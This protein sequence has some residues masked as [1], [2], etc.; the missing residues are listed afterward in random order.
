MI[1]RTHLLRGV[2]IAVLVLWAVTS[3]AEA[4]PDETTLTEPE[5]ASGELAVPQLRELVEDSWIEDDEIGYFVGG[6]GD[7]G[8]PTF[9]L[10]DTYWNVRLGEVLPDYTRRLSPIRVASW[11]DDSLA[12][13]EVGD[14]PAIGQ[15]GYAVDLALRLDIPFDANRVAIAIEELREGVQYKTAPTDSVGNWGSSAI[16][17]E[18]LAAAGLPIPPHLEGA[19]ADAISEYQL[20]SKA[21]SDPDMVVQALAPILSIA[22]YLPPNVVETGNLQ[23]LYDSAEAALDGAPTD[24]VGLA[25]RY[26][27]ISAGARLNLTV[28][29]DAGSL[30]GV[31][32]GDGL[33]RLPGT[34]DADPQSAYYALALGCKNAELPPE[35]P[36]SRAGWPVHDTISQTTGPTTAA[37]RLLIDVDDGVE[38]RINERLRETL[39]RFW[40][41]QLA[42]ADLASD[43]GAV[44]LA[45]LSEISHR[46]G[47]AAPDAVIS[48]A[49]VA[50]P[51]G[52]LARIV[53]L[54]YLPDPGVAEQE[55]AYRI[56]QET[57]E[58]ARDA[59]MLYAATLE[60]AARW[61]NNADLHS[62]AVDLAS[63]HRLSP[64]LYA[65]DSAAGDTASLTA[66]VIGVWI[67]REGE[68]PASDWM[69]A[70]LCNS[71]GACAETPDELHRTGNRSF[72]NLSVLWAC[73][74]PGCGEAFPMP[75]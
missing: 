39:D 74:K 20:L 25:T 58:F 9:S 28:R 66:S 21:N 47:R 12:G 38:E 48:P 53:A 41:P 30:C 35:R 33:V 16:A 60:V 26:R 63:E 62:R 23:N 52:G 50:G 13:R 61:L 3:C 2:S 46:V 45:R 22:S 27:L 71:N 67:H 44:L 59:P 18:T 54:S 40:L 51:V 70:G 43:S 36:Y 29:P 7:P 69:G 37:L 49:E 10:Y 73:R 65:F 24:P 56:V 17:V 1:T 4:K 15:I 19:V 8:V 55:A 64:R 75:L 32:D 42:E 5:G 6:V 68:S 31:V 57:E 14:L 34:Q 11:L 72:R